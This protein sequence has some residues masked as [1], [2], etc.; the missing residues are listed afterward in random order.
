MAPPTPRPTPATTSRFC[1]NARDA[2]SVSRAVGA[3]GVVLDQ[4]KGWPSP[5]SM[6]ADVAGWAAAGAVASID[7]LSGIPSTT[8]SGTSRGMTCTFSG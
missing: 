2:L 1:K 8:L 4:L 3:I 5:G 6:M 7:Q